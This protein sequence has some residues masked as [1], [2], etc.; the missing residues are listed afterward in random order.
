[1]RNYLDTLLNLHPTDAQIDAQFE[2][3]FKHIFRMFFEVGL[4]LFSAVFIAIAALC[5]FGR[6]L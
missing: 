1:M 3:S 2:P 6:S 5:L 4:V